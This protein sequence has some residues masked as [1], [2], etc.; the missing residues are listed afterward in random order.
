GPFVTEPVGIGGALVIRAGAGFRPVIELSEAGI[1]AHRPLLASRATLVLEG[2][3]LRRMPPVSS[4]SRT[5]TGGGALPFVSDTPLHVANCRLMPLVYR[6]T[7]ADSATT[8]SF[9]NC[10]F[11]K[12]G[13]GLSHRPGSRLTVEN[14]I[15]PGSGISL[16]SRLEMG[17]PATIR[18]IRNTFIRDRE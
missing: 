14:C 5:D 12:G 18:L 4:A 3:E 13:T 11:I 7:T 2:L 17:E 10:E 9:L 6:V 16:P 1:R 15:V 8:K